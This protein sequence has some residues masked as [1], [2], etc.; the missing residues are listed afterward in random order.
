MSAR[1]ILCELY[2]CSVSVCEQAE[3]KCECTD[4]SAYVVYILSTDETF[5]VFMCFQ[6]QASMIR[7]EKKH[8][9]CWCICDYEGAIQQFN[10][11]STRMP[12]TTTTH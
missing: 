6:T 7:L 4:V 10:G 12:R 11:P 3:E 1:R 2:N 8:N 5:F 9:M